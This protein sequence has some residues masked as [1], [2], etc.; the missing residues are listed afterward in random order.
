MAHH[1]FAF[2]LALVP[3]CFAVPILVDVCDV[4]S[5]PAAALVEAAWKDSQQW[6]V[7]ATYVQD[8]HGL[9]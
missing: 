5:V 4:G 7:L 9:P 8:G 2:F 3:H 1:L 6:F